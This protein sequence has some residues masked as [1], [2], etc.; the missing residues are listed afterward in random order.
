M[1]SKVILTNYSSLSPKINSNVVEKCVT[2]AS[3]SERSALI[4]EVCTRDATYGDGSATLYAM[5]KDQYAN[6][7]VQKM[8]EIAE[9][10]QRKLLLQRIRPY[11]PQLRKYTY[12]KHI[13]A[14]LEKFMI[15]NNN[16]VVSANN[17]NELLAEK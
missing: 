2:H 4:E 11:M 10:P 8:I 5:M 3:R 16:P 14:K 6:Y 7:V 15:K 12:G 13:L 9:P 1:S 17:N